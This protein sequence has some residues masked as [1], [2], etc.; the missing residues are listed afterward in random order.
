MSSVNDSV[1]HI[2][3]LRS[4]NDYSIEKRN[5]STLIPSKNANLPQ[6]TTFSAIHCGYFYVLDQCLRPLHHRSAVPVTGFR[7]SAFRSL[8]PLCFSQTRRKSSSCHYVFRRLASRQPY[9]INSDESRQRILEQISGFWRKYTI[10]STS[11]IISPHD[12]SLKKLR[13]GLSAH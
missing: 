2:L 5:Q 9:D 4:V 10:F 8:L 3:M 13:Q 1:L 12:I 11:D 7:K 6:W